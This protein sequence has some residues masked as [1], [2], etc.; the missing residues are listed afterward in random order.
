MIK[1]LLVDDNPNKQNNVKQTILD[2]HDFSESDI[3][4]VSCTKEARKLLYDNYFD[5]MILDLVLPIELNG[6]CNAKNGVDFLNEISINP[7][8]KPPIHIVGISGFQD[9]VLEFHDQFRMKLWNLIVYEESSSNWK[10]QLHSIIFHLVKTRQKFLSA[11]LDKQLSLLFAQLEDDNYPLTFLGCDWTT[12]CQNLA[13]IVEKSLDVPSRFSNGLK[14][15]NI[16]IESLK[17]TSE[18][19]FQNLVHLILRPWIPS[20]EAEN[21]AIIIDGNTKNADFSIKSNSIIIEAKYIDSTGKKND[22]LKTLEGLK[23]FYKMNANVK[24]LLFLIL[25]ED[26]VK[27]DFHKLEDQYSQVLAEPSIYVKFFL[28]KLC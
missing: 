22:T 16:N 23:D 15:K 10:D 19:D 24:S 28:N 26:S 20:T 4:I 11:S 6:E 13:S 8:I 3:D 25:V 18:Y 21:V 17:I 5:L 1:I 2:T 7:S 14:A 27:I 12:I 9:Q